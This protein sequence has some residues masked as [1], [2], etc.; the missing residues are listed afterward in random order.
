MKK[1]ITQTPQTA[2]TDRISLED[3]SLLCQ[4]DD[5]ME[6][7]IADTQE[8][9]MKNAPFHMKE[10]VLERQRQIDAPSK[11]P[12]PSPKI[13]LLRY[14]LQVS[15]AAVGAIILLFTW[16]E[17]GYFP[18]SFHKLYGIHQQ[19]SLGPSDLA[20]RRRPGTGR[21]GTGLSSADRLSGYTDK[22][23]Q[24]HRSSFDSAN[25]FSIERF[26]REVT[27]ND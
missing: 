1:Q 12:F 15:A 20:A 11:I 13:Q 10:E 14:S 5:W 19:I 16:P 9:H 6:Q 8:N 21:S 2:R 17:G 4:D 27:P 3:L 24:S 25:P 26:N 18:E 22:L 7:F 23:W